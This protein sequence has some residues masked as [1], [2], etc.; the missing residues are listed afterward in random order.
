[1]VVVVA[2]AV[3]NLGLMGESGVGLEVGVIRVGDAI[4]WLQRERNGGRECVYMFLVREGNWVSATWAY[5]LILVL[6]FM[7]DKRPNEMIDMDKPSAFLRLR[8]ICFKPWPPH[9]LLEK[10]Q[11]LMVD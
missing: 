7:D 6:C 11:P 8:F 5:H 3:A 4:V 2:V 9:G 10:L 1:M